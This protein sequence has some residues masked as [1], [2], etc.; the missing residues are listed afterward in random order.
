MWPN[1]SIL[2]HALLPVAKF[3]P[4]LQAPTPLPLDSLLLPIRPSTVQRSL[5]ARNGANRSREEPELL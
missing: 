5:V 4:G 3:P 1:D 2:P